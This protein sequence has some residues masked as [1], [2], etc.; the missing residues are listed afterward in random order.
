MQ[1]SGKGPCPA[2]VGAWR[3]VVD[4]RAFRALRP[5]PELAAAVSAP[6]YDVIDVPEARALAAGNPDSFLHVSRPEID[7]GDGVDADSPQVHAR[8]RAALDDLVARGVLVRDGLPTLSVY[9]QSVAGVSQTGVACCVAVAD[10]A[11]GTVRI[12]EFTRPDKE[13]DRTRHVDALDANDEPVFLLAQP[14]PAVAAVI[15]AVTA[16]APD[17]DVTAEDGVRHTLWVLADPVAI[18]EVVAAYAGHAALWVADGHHRSAAAQRVL[19]ARQ[20]EGRLVGGEDAFLAVVFAADEPTVLAYHRVVADLAGYDPASLLAALAASFEVVAADGP[21]EPAACREFGVYL[22]GGWYRLRALPGI[23]DQ[24]DPVARLDVSV[25]QDRV[26]APLLGID[27]PRRDPRIRFVGGSRGTAE[28]QR[29]VDAGEAAVAFSLHPTSVADLM[30][31]AD[32]G[33]VMPPKSTWFEPK[34]RSGLVV[35]PFAP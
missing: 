19:A 6:P 21:V 14:D 16:S 25:L 26:L 32:A 24:D 34:L 35:H 13:A 9:R 20:A 31:L 4:I 15:D 29:Q 30:A 2:R 12:H 28:L 5:R 7:L 3:L 1:G 22:P 23:V 18:A 10:Y 17:V 11:D 33:L 8:G 27:D